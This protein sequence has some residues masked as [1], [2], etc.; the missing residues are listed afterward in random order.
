M[1]TITTLIAAAVVTLAV[2]LAHHP[3]PARASSHTP[4]TNGFVPAITNPY[5]PYTP[6]S[7]WVYKGLKDGVTQTDTVTVTHKTRTIQGIKATTITDIATHGTR[8]LE[9]T[10][11]W[12]A[13]DTH[14]NVWYLGEATKAYTASGNVDT[15]GS[16]LAGRYGAHRGIVMTAH[17]KVD[18]AHRQEIL[19][20]ATPKTNTGSLTSTS[21]SRHHT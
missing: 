20:P 6:G 3:R 14:G 7:R 10:I 11:D 8:V 9:S 17:P 19:G 18:D 5:L 12:Y 13:Q 4:A 2:A 16:W 15:S 1:I 21:K